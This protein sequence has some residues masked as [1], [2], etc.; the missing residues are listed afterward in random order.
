M[1]SRTELIYYVCL[2]DRLLAWLI[3]PGHVD[4]VQSRVTSGNLATDARAFQRAIIEGDQ[5]EFSRLSEQLFTSLIEPFLAE[6]HPGDT[7]VLIPDESLH[8]VP[9]AALKNPRTGRYVIEDH[10]ITVAPSATMFARASDR[11]RSLSPR[12]NRV[13]VVANPQI[14]PADASNLTTLAGAEDEARRIAAA[15]PDS[16]V[17][18][19]SRASKAE[20]MKAAGAFDIVHFGGHAIAND[21]YPLLSRLIFARGQDHSGILFSHELLEMQFDRTS[22][23]VLAAC[24]TAVGPLKK[25]EGAI[26]LARPFLARGVPAVLATLWDVD[27]RASDVLFKAFYMNLRS[28]R[29]PVEALRE[30]QLDLLRNA[31]AR[32]HKPAAWAGFITTGGINDEVEAADLNGGRQ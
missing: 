30:A 7:L 16:V 27:D 4:L 21:T 9:F 5:A 8:T 13:F 11:L 20:F 14:D 26:S 1:S 15:Y 29:Q 25:G 32:W 6:I 10:A 18:T 17:L 22:L 31:D 3:R 19:G 28:G 24:S 23:V 2:S 12:A